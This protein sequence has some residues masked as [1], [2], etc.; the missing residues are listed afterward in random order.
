MVMNDIMNNNFSD[1]AQEGCLIIR[2]DVPLQLV[3]GGII[4]TVLGS[5]GRSKTV[6][7]FNT[8]H[9]SLTINNVNSL[10]YIL[11]NASI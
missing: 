11:D 2:Y 7:I 1:P 6:H 10:F 9:S 4:S 5:D 8:N 3:A